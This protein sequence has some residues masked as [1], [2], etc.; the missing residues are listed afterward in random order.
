MKFTALYLLF[1]LA[2]KVA[3]NKKIGQIQLSG[4]F[5][6]QSLIGWHREVWVFGYYFRGELS[7]ALCFG[8][9]V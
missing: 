2:I 4:Q 5:G 7:G 8:M 6:R 3:L 9:I 1:L